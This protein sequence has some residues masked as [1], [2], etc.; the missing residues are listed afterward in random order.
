[1]QIPLIKGDRQSKLDYRE[2]LPV[3]F[4]SVISQIKGSEGYLLSH[5]GFPHNVTIAP[6]YMS[7]A[8]YIKA[9]VTYPKQVL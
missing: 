7:G 1:M 8:M 5:D 6:S 3:N 2:N 9:H 4:T